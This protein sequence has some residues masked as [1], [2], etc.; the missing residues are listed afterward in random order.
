M[1]LS[2]VSLLCGVGFEDRQYQHNQRNTRRR[3]SFNYLRE[4]GSESNFILVLLGFLSCDTEAMHDHCSDALGETNSQ[5]MKGCV[6]RA[7]VHAQCV[8]FYE[9]PTRFTSLLA[10]QTLSLCSW[11]PLGVWSTCYPNFS[12]CWVLPLLYP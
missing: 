1:Q 10:Y 7:R 8:P 5:G 2:A 4:N 11:P 9:C 12:L 3:E 6:Y